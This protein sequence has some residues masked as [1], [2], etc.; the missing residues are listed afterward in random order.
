MFIKTP[1]KIMRGEI[2]TLLYASDEPVI[3]N[4]GIKAFSIIKDNNQPYLMLKSRSMKLVHN[5]ILIDT[6]RI[7]S[8]QDAGVVKTISESVMDGFENFNNTLDTGDFVDRIEVDAQPDYIGCK[9]CVITSKE[10]GHWTLDFI[11]KGSYI[12]EWK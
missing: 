12:I 9:V 5:L 10:N 6:K 4:I 3:L 1:C 2:S 8:S 7:F 11:Y